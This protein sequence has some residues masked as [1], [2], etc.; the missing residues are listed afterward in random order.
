M[1][2][3]LFDFYN[4][5]TFDV[6]SSYTIREAYL[7]SYAPGALP[8]FVEKARDSAKEHKVAELNHDTV[9]QSDFLK[10]ELPSSQE[11]PVRILHVTSEL[12]YRVHG[13]R[14][15]DLMLRGVKPLSVFSDAYRSLRHKQ[16]LIDFFEPQVRLGN[17][18]K[19]EIQYPESDNDKSFVDVF[20][21]LPNENWRFYAYEFL[22]T[23]ASEVFR[24][25]DTLEFIQGS[26]LGYRQEESEFW[27][28]R[29]QKRGERW[30][31]RQYYTVLDSA[32]TE[33]IRSN[34][35]KI[36]VVG[37][38]EPFYVYLPRGLK[39]RDEVG[40]AF[41]RQL[42]NAVVGFYAP[43]LR[44]DKYL[45]TIV[46]IGGLEFTRF[47]VRRSELEYVNSIIDGELEIL[48]F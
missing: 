22:L 35:R 37:D 19:H 4:L 29:Q 39:A 25:N 36:L 23:A 11:F 28:A 14:E 32:S 21:C 8:Q 9:L 10:R 17:L 44:F 46:E 12:P 15:Y 27:L 1:V 7:E 31:L 5:Q 48:K 20:Y 30:G 16:F 26:L 33:A 34:Y 24:W 6:A 43:H 3:T 18:I 13:G 41:A 47:E 45:S 2:N 42:H 38:I 40:A